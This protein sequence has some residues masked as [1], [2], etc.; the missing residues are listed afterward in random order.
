M[1]YMFLGYCYQTSVVLKLHI[2]VNVLI[3][4]CLF[5][6]IRE[7]NYPEGLIDQLLLHCTVPRNLT[8]NAVKLNSIIHNPIFAD[9]GFNA[10]MVV[11]QTVFN[12]RIVHLSTNLSMQPSQ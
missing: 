9:L 8:E 12:R 7:L 2:H 11:L 3:K 4:T 6:P 1:R 5:Q 10:A